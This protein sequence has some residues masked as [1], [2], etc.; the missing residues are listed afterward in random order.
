MEL[1]SERTIDKHRHIN[2]E[3]MEQE[4]DDDSESVLYPT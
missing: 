2:V 4:E 3:C 1:V